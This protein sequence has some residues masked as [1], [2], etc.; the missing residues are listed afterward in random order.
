MAAPAGQEQDMAS[1]AAGGRAAARLLLLLA[2][3]GS[4][5]TGQYSAA[6]SQVTAPLRHS[7]A[8]LVLSSVHDHKIAFLERKK[9]SRFLSN[10]NDI[11]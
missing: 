8:E 5:N 10:D 1:S 3:V 4:L 6:A 7:R 9:S 2:A 11:L